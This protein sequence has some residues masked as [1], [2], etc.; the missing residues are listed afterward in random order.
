MSQDNQVVLVSTTN[1]GYL[2]TVYA[3]E[4]LERKRILYTG[5]ISDDLKNCYC[6]CMGWSLLEKCYHQTNAKKIMEI[7]IA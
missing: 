5:E 7:P 3:K 6:D 4:D 2:Y 1:H